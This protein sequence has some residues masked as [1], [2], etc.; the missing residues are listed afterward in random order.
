MLRSVSARA[1]EGVDSTSGHAGER[2][3]LVAEMA[4]VQTPA[5]GDVKDMD[6]AEAASEHGISSTANLIASIY[7][8]RSY[9][10]SHLYVRP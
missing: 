8:Q 4:V 9:S 2:A 10:S 1:F 7:A 3:E 5:K 6:V